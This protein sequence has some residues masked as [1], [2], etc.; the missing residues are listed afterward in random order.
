M[1]EAVMP[2][3]SGEPASEAEKPLPRF[4]QPKA[5]QGGRFMIGYAV[6][7]VMVGV[8]LIALAYMTRDTG[9]STQGSTAWGGLAVHENG[10][11]RA[12][13]IA[14]EVSKRYRG[15]NGEQIAA[16]TAQPGEISGLPLQYIALRHGR[17]RPLTQ[18]DV[19]TVDP[20]ETA[21][22]SFCG[23]GG[24]Q[25]CSLPGQPSA[26]R[27]VLLRREA[28]ELS[29]H[30]FKHLPE[31]NTVVSLL[32]PVVQ[33]EGQAPQGLAVWFER[34]HL[35]NVLSKPLAATLP[36]PPPY[37]QG[38][39]TPGETEMVNNLTELRF[40]NSSFEQLPTQ[41]VVLNLEPPTSQ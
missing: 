28:L 10:F 20:G 6:V 41:G 35:E 19:E 38:D 24:Q 15:A 18:G 22:F 39:I 17:N 8:A 1:A 16:V 31:I 11:E 37:V 27:G 25:N 3:R 7:V 26:E 5:V 12:R 30:T 32:P 21:L 33:A 2:E 9:S 23:L 13:E 14:V 4:E 36:E 29:L 40:F 34:R